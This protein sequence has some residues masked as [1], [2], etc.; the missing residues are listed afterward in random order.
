MENFRAIAQ[1]FASVRAPTGEDHELL[2][3]ETVVGVRSAVDDVHH[4]HRQER[5]ALPPRYWYSA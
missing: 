4:R 1:G 3:I 5:G 2:D